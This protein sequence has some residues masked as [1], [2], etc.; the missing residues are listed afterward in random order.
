M[1]FVKANFE[2][3]KKV[4]GGDNNQSSLVLI[5]TPLFSETFGGNKILQD[6]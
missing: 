2:H 5:G 4:K 6:T 3:L 1:A